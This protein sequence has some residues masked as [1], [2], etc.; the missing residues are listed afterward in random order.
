LYIFRLLGGW[1]I[2]IC[3]SGGVGWGSH[4]LA[5]V[6]NTLQRNGYLEALIRGLG[7]CNM[8]K[9]YT[10]QNAVFYGLWALALVLV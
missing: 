7:K 8:K 9:V 3:I 1:S 5:F 10:H 2:G 6:P 4:T